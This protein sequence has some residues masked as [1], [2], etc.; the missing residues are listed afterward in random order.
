[1]TFAPDTMRWFVLAC[2]LFVQSASAYFD[3]PYITPANPRAGE[4]LTINMDQGVCDSVVGEPGYPQVTQ[5]GRSIRVLLFAFRY[6]NPIFCIFPHNTA[7]VPFGSFPAGTYSVTIDVFYYGLHGTPQ[8]ATL[9]V[10]PIVVSGAG[11]GAVP[12]PALGVP[13]SLV[14]IVLLTIAARR[15]IAGTLRSSFADEPAST[16]SPRDAP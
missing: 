3:A 8:T 12:A 13:L 7:V 16:R 1:M 9:A 5:D 4:Q 6:D 14:L 10:L 15:R 11:S 2:A